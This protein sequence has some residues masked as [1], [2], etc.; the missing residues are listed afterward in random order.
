MLQIRHLRLCAKQS[1]CASWLAPCSRAG[2]TSW[3]RACR[4]RASS[5]PA[6]HPAS[7]ASLSM[8]LPGSR[9]ALNGVGA[10]LCMALLRL[11]AHV[12]G[13][14]FSLL[15]ASPGAKAPRTRP[16]A[17]QRTGAARAPA[18]RHEGA[19]ARGRSC[20]R[21]KWDTGTHLAQMRQPPTE[22][23]TQV[24]HTYW[25]SPPTIIGTQGHTSP[26]NA[27]SANKVDRADRKKGSRMRGKPVNV[28]PC[29]PLFE[30]LRRETGCE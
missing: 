16:R 13:H 7:G 21:P 24:G 5:L 25:G 22:V 3:A 17:A 30:N 28:C 27:V 12:A 23:G 8:T 20:R 14:A 19:G 29:V 11:A 10:L 2:A 4:D 9:P 6:T 1:P 26:K 18:G 15:D